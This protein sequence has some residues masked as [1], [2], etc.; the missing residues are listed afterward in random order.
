MIARLL[1]DPATLQRLSAEAREHARSWSARGSMARRL[2]RCTGCGPGPAQARFAWEKA[3]RQMLLDD[4]EVAAA[5]ARWLVVGS[6]LALGGRSGLRARDHD[7]PGYITGLAGVFAARLGTIGNL[8]LECHALAILARV[9]RN[10]V[11]NR[12][13]QRLRHPAETR[14]KA[15]QVVRHVELVGCIG[16]QVEDDLA[17]ARVTRWHARVRIHDSGEI[18][19]EPWSTHHS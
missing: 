6:V 10:H 16:R 4:L 19:R 8:C 11:G 15:D 14:L 18:G 7:R 5:P 9:D 1:D 13:R 12:N 2:A 3:R 17:I